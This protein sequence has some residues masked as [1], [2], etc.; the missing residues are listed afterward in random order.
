MSRTTN[1][2]LDDFDILIMLFLRHDVTIRYL[3]NVFGWSESTVRDRCA[4]LVKVGYAT[5]T[6][7]YQKW[8]KSR[9]KLTPEGEQFAENMRILSN[10]FILQK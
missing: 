7:G 3:A 6:D 1:I 10:L 2:A 4:R 8:V 9:Y 5:R